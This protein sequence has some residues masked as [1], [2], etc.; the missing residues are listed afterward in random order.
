MRFAKLFCIA[1]SILIGLGTNYGFGW[2]VTDMSPYRYIAYNEWIFISSIVYLISLLGYK[3]TLLLLYLRLFGVEKIFRYATWT[4]MFFVF[5]YLFSNLLTH[6]F[7]C[8]PID[9]YWNP[10]TSGHCVVL[11][12][13]VYAYGSMNCISD[14]FI[15]VLPLPMVWRMQLSRKDK[16]GVTL[17][18]MS[19]AIA[20]VVAIV[21]Y[22]LLLHRFHA[23][24]KTWYD[25]IFLNANVMLD[26][27]TALSLAGN[28]VQFV[29]FGCTL[30]AKAHEVYSSNSGTSEESL[31]ME[32]VTS[33]LLGI[34]HDIESHLASVH[35]STS[36]D[37]I[38]KSSRRLLEIADACKM[39]A[40]DIL[41]R[42]EGMK[43][44]Q[45]PSVWTSVRQALK[46]M[47]TKDELDA[48]MKRLKAYISELDTAILV[49]I[50][51]SI[52]L[53]NFRA[54]QN[55]YKLDEAAQRIV[56][57][58]LLNRSVFTSALRIHTKEIKGVIISEQAQTR[59]MILDLVQQKGISQ[60]T[61]ASYVQSL[62]G[63]EPAMMG[64]DEKEHSVRRWLLDSLGF[65]AMQNRQE[66]VAQAYHTTFEWMFEEPIKETKPLPWTNFVEW[67]RNGDGIY[68]VNGKAGSGK[69]TLMKY[70]YNDNR[71]S[72]ILSQ[73]SGSMPVLVATFFFW[74]SGTQEQR[75]QVGLLR[76]L[77][78]QVLHHRP[79]LI[80][81]VFPEEY[82]MLR[83][84]PPNAV[85]DYPR[86]TWSL[87]RLQA[88]VQ[89][90]VDIQD[91][92]L[93]VCFFID[94]LDEF[95]GNDDQDDHQY[96]IELFRSL[97]S[98]PSI[99]VCL[100]SRPLLIFEESF[101]ESPGLRLQDLTS[102]DIRRFVTDRLSNDPRMRQIAEDK[103]S[104]R[105]DFEKEICNKAQGVFLWVKLVVRSLLDGVSNSDRMADLRARL[106]LLPADLEE[107]YRHMMAKTEKIYLKGASEVFQLVQ[108]AR[109]VQNMKRNDNQRT[110]PV[111]V[112]LLALAIEGT[113]GAAVDI[114][115]DPWTAQKLSS[116][117]DVMRRRLQT[118]CAGMIEVPDFI[119]NRVDPLDPN[120]ALRTKI[121]W[122]VAYLHRTA[123][124]F[125]ES[126]PV[127]GM[128]LKRTDT[129]F[130]PYTSLIQSTVLLYKVAGPLVNNPL[131]FGLF[132]KE[133]LEPALYALLF[134]ER[135]E[136][137]TGEAHLEILEELDNVMTRHLIRWTGDYSGHWSRFLDVA[138]APNC[139][140]SFVDLAVFY[141]LHQF[142]LAKIASD[143][144]QYLNKDKVKE[145]FAFVREYF[146]QDISDPEAPVRSVT[147]L[148]IA[149][150]P[151]CQ[152]SEMAHI[153]LEHG[154][155]P[156]ETSGYE[157]R[158]VWEYVLK[159]AQASSKQGFC[160]GK[161]LQILKLFL[162]Y[163]VDLRGYSIDVND[164]RR[165]ILGVIEGFEAKYPTE[166]ASLRANID[167][168][169][170][171][172]KRNKM[173]LWVSEKLGSKKTSA[174][175]I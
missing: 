168:K 132:R 35:P 167:K 134:A 14:L 2:H 139:F 135:A 22:G 46:I 34:V 84:Q 142:V 93:K 151:S 153:L 80:H 172:K 10:K 76:S 124:D 150:R 61:S 129:K 48:L 23:T 75:S 112:L 54:S 57:L 141:G 43:I 83:D 44:R 19:G 125:I 5:G 86:H 175:Q 170:P 85:R 111:T 116:L 130:D 148:D 47:W 97:A 63:Q 40:E 131:G 119:W 62:D 60:A 6:I 59:A 143:Y 160:E 133:L 149:V 101:K 96:L 88:A 107:L 77:L 41:R 169:L 94:G 137:T 42:L 144:V 108:T 99:K 71:T 100:S 27:L 122:E 156:N 138:G 113:S 158:S 15:F 114:A 174:H 78:F 3:F 65:A 152:G 159:R 127:W 162:Q 64:I 12:K 102:K 136:E 16:I 30:A 105:H 165:R 173:K 90:L 147:L 163:N 56:D 89:R 55:F 36:P 1:Y 171:D 29:Q 37:S 81:L 25:G 28:V 140:C 109:Q 32:S 164:T 104:Q 58:L 26:P 24:D 68:W 161:W 45:P 70:I 79:A 38:S 115:S 110:T 120:A 154:A 72:Q 49:S 69:S 20:F 87:R 157:R 21:R 7:G 13:A 82:G 11:T 146:T 52:D 67:L 9:K 118:W 4:V 155:D 103:S 18:F 95:E 51:R 145:D 98:S 53:A 73:W 8:S 106:E 126:K 123:R 117:C 33:R 39:I 50:K 128:L 166:V 31:E 66:E 17:V 92:Q 91:L 121:T 74:N